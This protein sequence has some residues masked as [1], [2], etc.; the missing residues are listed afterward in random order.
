MKNRISAI[1]IDKNHLD[2]DYTLLNT[3]V[4]KKWSTGMAGETGFDIVVLDDDSKILNELAKN[5]IID[6]IVSVG[7]TFDNWK[8]LN[9]LSIEYRKKWTYVKEFDPVQI[10]DCIVSTFVANLTRD[11]KPLGIVFSVFTCTFNTPSNFF[12]RLY[13]SLKNQTYKNWNWFIF[14]D[15][16]NPYI[17]EKLAKIADSRITVVKNMSGH[18]IIGAN[19]R[20]IAM[21]CTGDYLVEVDHDDEL[22]PDCFEKLNKA[23]QKYPDSDFLYSHALEMIGDHPV[24]YSIPFAYGLGKYENRIVNGKEYRVALTAPINEVSIRGIHACPNHVRVWKRDFYHSIN[25][26]NVD[27][28]CIDD[29]ELIIRTFLYGKMTMIDDV[30][31]I[32]WQDDKPGG[33]K[34]SSN[35][36]GKR[37]A[38]IQRMNVYVR[39]QYD[40]LIHN[41]VLD[42]GGQ[43]I[44]WND[45]I[46]HYEIGKFVENPQEIK[47]LCNVYTCTDRL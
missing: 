15:S 42:L 47:T 17:S 7:E 37:F 38:E 21:M 32:Q 6:A 13:N 34:N 2:H 5:R 3:D 25:G 36:Q 41:R 39:Y 24:N 29:L 40:N 1:I 4:C 43:D 20:A 28:S 8:E 30:L 10:V 45:E 27:M 33:R 44:Y 35:T 12:D 31:Y 26:H 19:K 16:T 9:N 46:G 23:I 14:D 11:T 22:T 18:G